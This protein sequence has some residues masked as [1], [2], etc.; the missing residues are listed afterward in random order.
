MSAKNET[1]SERVQKY[2]ESLGMEGGID[3]LFVRNLA[4][5]LDE[6]RKRLLLAR[7]AMYRIGVE[8]DLVLAEGEKEE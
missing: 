7:T 1:A 3:P 2:V 8:V 5:E 4:R 6:T